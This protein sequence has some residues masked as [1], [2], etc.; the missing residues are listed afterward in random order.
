MTKED[1]NQIAMIVKTEVVSLRYEMNKRFEEQEERI[2]KR[3]EEQEGRIE[4]KFKSL[5]SEIIETINREISKQMLLF[6]EHY[7]RALTIAVECL[8]SK[9]ALEDVQNKRLDI[10]ENSNNINSAAVFNREKRINY[11]EKTLQIQVSK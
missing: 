3:F 1:L 6:E 10:L 5:G 9:S 11:L 8:N 2:N 4:T 7:G